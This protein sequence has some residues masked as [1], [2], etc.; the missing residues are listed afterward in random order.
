MKWKLVVCLSRLHSRFELCDATVGI[1]V[2]AVTITIAIHRCIAYFPNRSI[3]RSQN[4]MCFVSHTYLASMDTIRKGNQ[5]AIHRSFLVRSMQHVRNVSTFNCP[6]LTIYNAY[7]FCVLL[8]LFVLLLFTL[9]FS[10]RYEI[11]SNKN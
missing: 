11:K 1:A 8:L 2:T 6:A 4:V 9:S 7:Y 10:E 3:E 5:N